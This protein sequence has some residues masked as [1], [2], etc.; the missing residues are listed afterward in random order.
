M[1]QLRVLGGDIRQLQS[2]LAEEEAAALSGVGDR[3]LR[4]ARSRTAQLE[5]I[6][7]REETPETTSLLRRK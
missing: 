3:S 4:G 1:A 2:Q 6:D 5:Q 7:R